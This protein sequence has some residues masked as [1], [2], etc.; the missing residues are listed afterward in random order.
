MHKNHLRVALAAAV[1]LAPLTGIAWAQ[2][3]RISFTSSSGSVNE[4]ATADPDSEDALLEVTVRASNLPAG[5]AGQDAD[6]LPNARQRAIDALGDITIETEGIGPREAA[7]ITPVYDT[8]TA[9]DEDAVF[10]AS[11][12]FQLTITPVQDADSLND[13]FTLRLRSTAA[14]FTGS[15]FRGTV[16][17]DDPLATAS[18][19]RTAIELRERTRT[20]LGVSVDPTTGRNFPRVARTQY[21]VLTATPARAVGVA[22]CPAEGVSGHLLRVWSQT[23]TLALGSRPGEVTIE[24]NI[25]DYRR[26]P[27][28]L[29]VDACGDMSDFRDAT[30]T[31]AFKESALETPDGIIAAGPPA[32]I[33]I[34]NN[35]PA[36]TV[37]LAP[38]AIAID[39]GMTESFAIVADGSLANA[40]TRVRLAVA[41]EARISL[42][43]D[44]ARLRRNTRATFIA[45]LD[46]NAVLRVTIRAD[47]DESLTDNQT[48]TATVTIVDA[49]GAEIGDADTLTV[50]VRGSTAVPVLPTIGQLLL[51]VLL[52]AGGLRLHS[53]RTRTARR[54]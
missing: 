52:L 24:R 12:S 2:T 9:L 4:G 7:T 41:G 15:A 51:T 29:W 45:D 44:G 49:G 35:D 48:K 19:S 11:D 23:A 47:E 38:T 20:Q 28:E 18:F 22:E 25:R 39:E 42:V 30:I 40:V 27:A 50:T 13:T 6:G 8:A 16:I 1:L 31:L 34:L 17:D 3:P 26:G 21:I 33:R 10:A 53:T 43:E 46:G 37:S 5:P 54:L 14:I 36:P 32:V